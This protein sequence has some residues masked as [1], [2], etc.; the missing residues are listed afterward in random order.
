[1]KPIAKKTTNSDCPTVTK[2]LIAIVQKLQ[3]YLSMVEEISSSK[4]AYTACQYLDSAD[5]AGRMKQFASVALAELVDCSRG[6]I[7][8]NE[9]TGLCLPEL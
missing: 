3:K 4:V 5:R 6:F 1:M 8:Q 7:G 9:V 2:I